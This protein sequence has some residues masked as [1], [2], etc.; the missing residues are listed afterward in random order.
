[1]IFVDHVPSS[2]QEQL[3][4]G[5]GQGLP[6]QSIGSA[7]L[8]S[9]FNPTASLILKKLLVVPSITKNLV[10]VSRFARDN[11]VFFSFHANHCCVRHQDTYEL[12]L[13]GAVG[14]DGLYYFDGP[15]TKASSQPAVN[16]SSLSSLHSQSL[17]R[18]SQACLASKSAENKATSAISLHSASVS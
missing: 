18:S 14:D 2:S 5:N 11:N 17:S 7:L 16:V 8:P 15:L 1:G 4:V 10:S 13:T 3:L 12:L 9:S 6:I